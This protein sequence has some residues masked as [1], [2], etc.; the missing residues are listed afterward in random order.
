MSGTLSGIHQYTLH[1]TA[2]N[3]DAFVLV[4]V[5]HTISKNACRNAS[6]STTVTGGT[7]VVSGSVL[8]AGSLTGT[9]SPRRVS[10]LRPLTTATSTR[11][12]AAGRSTAGGVWVYFYSIIPNAVSSSLW[13]NETLLANSVETAATA[14]GSL[15]ACVGV[16]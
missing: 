7:S 3:S 12:H 13:M 2:T 14:S 9:H 8:T 11:A 6:V 10:A 16:V 4:D 1:G 5:C 15:G